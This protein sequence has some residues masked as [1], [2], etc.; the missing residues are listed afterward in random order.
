MI[1]QNQIKR[2]LSQPGVI[3]DIGQQLTECDNFKLSDFVD[4]LCLQHGFIDPQG[5]YQQSGCLKALRVLEQAQKITLPQ[6][7]KVRKPR[8]PQRSEQPLPALTDIPGE[9]SQLQG[10]VL[11][12]IT[13]QQ[14]SCIWNEMMA[15]NHPRKAG[16]LVGRQLRYLVESDHGV[17]GGFAFS[18][19][20]L[21][22]HDRDRWIGWTFE[23]RQE[24]LQMLVNMSRFL[25]RPEVHCNNLASHLLGQVVRRMPD[26]F[27]AQY[28]YR[29]LLLESFVDTQ[30]YSGTCYN[31]HFAYI[32]YKFT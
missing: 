21:N 20:A 19:A 4:K 6:P 18:S 31:L 7:K 3:D 10:L 12:L 29:P 14:Q 24:N 30:Y 15:S 13:T 9:I 22:L 26:D 32:F 11:T 5:N 2:T 25:I 17:L 16:P 27:A 28:G 23:S 1:K 8:S